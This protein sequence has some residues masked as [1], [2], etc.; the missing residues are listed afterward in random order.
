M[1]AQDKPLG[2]LLQDAAGDI[3]DIVRKEA[4]LAQTEIR[5]NLRHALAGAVKALLGAVVLIPALTVALLA[6]A[7]G[8]D[9]YDVVPRW[10]AALIA[11]L[12]GGLIGAILLSMGNKALEA[13]SLAPTRTM[14]N[15]KQDAQLIKEQVR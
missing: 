4:K 14:D 15:L 3:A 13:G 12:V 11:A 7:W 5:D 10:A 9:D 1:D 6:L 8:L 2:S